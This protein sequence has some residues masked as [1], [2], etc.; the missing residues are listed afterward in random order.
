MSGPGT[1]LGP[2]GPAPESTELWK[3][4]CGLSDDHNNNNNNININY[5][6][7]MSDGAAGGRHVATRTDLQSPKHRS[8]VGLNYGDSP[9]DVEPTQDIFWDPVSPVA[10][11][12]NNAV[13][14]ISDIVNRIAPKDAERHRVESPLLQWIGDSAVPCTPDGP[15]QRVRKRSSRQSSVDDLLKLARQ[16][17]QNMQEDLQ[18]SADA[19]GTKPTDAGRPPSTDPVEAELNALFDCSTQRVSGGLSQSSSAERRPTCDD[20]DDD[21]EDDDLLQDCFEL[22][23]T[24]NAEQEGEGL[25][26]PAPRPN[27]QTKPAPLA[28]ACRP[29][30]CSA[31][32]ELCP[33]AKRSNRSTFKLEPHPP[34]RT[35]QVSG[36]T[37][38][39]AKASQ[40]TP[41]VPVPQAVPAD[42]LW[43]DGVDDALLCQVCDRVERTSGPPPPR[44]F[45]R[46]N[47]LPGGGGEPGNYRGWD[48]P[49]KGADSR[50]SISRSLPGGRASLG[51][52]NQCGDSS[53]APPSKPRPPT[54]K[55][56]L[57]DSAATSSKV[58][59]PS[60]TVSKCTAAEI[61]RKKQEALARRRL[62]MQNPP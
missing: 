32:W 19:P 18:T 46:S 25:H 34:V 44:C 58:F 47:S 23:M 12:R 51:S 10:G 38:P 35:A 26:E 3:R 11:L 9:S 16:F 59:V 37:R 15:K 1:R 50:S 5:Y 20:F 30:S 61:G 49:L 56:N 7:N 27:P 2:A 14:E 39:S 28:S 33:T 29:P 31:L 41:S 55:R 54:F 40:Q 6:G 52:F 22:A 13:V 42:S 62:R 21:W 45:V 17:D 60:Q 8:S 4:V 36:S 48:A 24:H 57:S 53:E 43:D